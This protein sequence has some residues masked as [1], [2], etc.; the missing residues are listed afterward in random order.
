MNTIAK[1][2]IATFLAICVGVHIYGLYY[3]LYNEPEWSHFVH[4][5]S[6][7]LCL[8]TFLRPVELRL[9]LYFTGTIYPFFYH[10]SCFFLGLIE[11]HKFNYICFEVIIVLPLAG[12]LL[13]L[14]QNRPA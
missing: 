3:R 4:I 8:Y 11:M 1:I 12:L 9:P 14:K 6:Y 2:L 7:S 10:A 13:I 5:L